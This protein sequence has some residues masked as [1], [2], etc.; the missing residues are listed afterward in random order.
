MNTD[1]KVCFVKV[2][3]KEVVNELVLT[4]H[5]YEV[6]ALLSKSS[7][8]RENGDTRLGYALV[9]LGPERRY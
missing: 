6:M 2:A 3:F 5:L 1:S 7:N 4:L 9:F 8:S